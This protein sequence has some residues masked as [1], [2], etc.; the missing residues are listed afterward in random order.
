M[1]ELQFVLSTAMLISCA[2]TVISSIM[3]AAK[4]IDDVNFVAASGC[5]A[6]EI[7]IIRMALPPLCKIYERWR[8]KGR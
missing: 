8:V 4:I 5:L 3:L 7:S 2:V 1:K 6:A